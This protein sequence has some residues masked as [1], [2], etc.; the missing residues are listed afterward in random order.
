MQHA[1]AIACPLPSCRSTCECAC[2]F[3]CCGVWWKLLQPHRQQVCD[4]PTLPKADDLADH[5]TPRDACAEGPSPTAQARTRRGKRRRTGPV[6][7]EA[8]DRSRPCGPAPATFQFHDPSACSATLLPSDL[9]RPNC[10]RMRGRRQSSLSRRCGGRG[11][12]VRGARGLAAG[13]DPADPRTC[14]VPAPRRP[15][16]WVD[17]PSLPARSNR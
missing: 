10:T 12:G 6:G 17:S 8:R 11:E 16:L 3:Y 14:P 1:Y 7:K 2:C 9:S 15:L 4:L 13:P 5:P